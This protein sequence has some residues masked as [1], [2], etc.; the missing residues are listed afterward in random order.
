MPTK[1]KAVAMHL[2]SSHAAQLAVNTDRLDRIEPVLER[3]MMRLDGIEVQLVRNKG[4][5]GAVTLI[6]SA[7]AA[8]LTLFKDNLLAALQR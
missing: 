1:K 6:G 7:I 2:Y 5:W 4:F 8:F 3:I